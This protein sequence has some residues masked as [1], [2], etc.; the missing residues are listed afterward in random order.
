MKTNSRSTP[1]SKTK[2]RRET[3]VEERQAI[4]PHN[5]APRQTHWHQK[6]KADLTVWRGS[7][8]N[9][10]SSSYGALGRGQ[11]KKVA[12]LLC[13]SPIPPPLPRPSLSQL[14]RNTSLPPLISDTPVTVTA[15]QRPHTKCTWTLS[16]AG[17][18]V[19]CITVRRVESATS[20]H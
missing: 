20:I 13:R 19:L 7:S 12:L 4:K 17:F 6:A 14:H 10:Y 16:Q 15:M 5:S 9:Y 2:K 8:R 3:G 1:R 18:G 11:K